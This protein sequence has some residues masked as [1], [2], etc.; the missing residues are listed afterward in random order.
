MNLIDLIEHYK[1]V[2]NELSF[3]RSKAVEEITSWCIPYSEHIVKLAIFG[4]L[5]NHNY[6][7]PKVRQ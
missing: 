6:D 5:T 4:K 3:T 2:F 7:V 1:K